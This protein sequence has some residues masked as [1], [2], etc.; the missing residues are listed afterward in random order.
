MLFSLAIVVLL[1]RPLKGPGDGN[2]RDLGD[3]EKAL[4]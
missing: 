2:R 3:T 1:A 4:G